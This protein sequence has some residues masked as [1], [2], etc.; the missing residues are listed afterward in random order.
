MLFEG[1]LTLVPRVERRPVMRDA[2]LISRVITEE[3]R[4]AKTFENTLVALE[5]SYRNFV[6]GQSAA[7]KLSSVPPTAPEFLALRAVLL[8]HQKLSDQFESYAE[9]IDFIRRNTIAPLQVRVSARAKALLE[10]EQKIQAP[11]LQ[12]M[13]NLHKGIDNY[14]KKVAK[15]KQAAQNAGKNA[16]A[17]AVFA[18]SLAEMN[19]KLVHIEQHFNA[20]QLAYAE[21]SRAR[22][23]LLGEVDAFVGEV[24][25]VFEESAKNLASIDA[26]I[27]EQTQSVVLAE[28]LEDEVAKLWADPAQEEKP[29]FVVTLDRDIVVDGKQLLAKNKYILVEAEGDQWRISNRDE[30]WVVPAEIVEPF[31][32]K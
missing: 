3:A 22:E 16:Q 26:A 29:P 10:Q 14:P 23:R 13:A 18:K 17:Q 12:A 20:F 30:S 1:N 7:P 5:K 31:E 2:D 4:F 11:C 9:K 32:M 19:E 21:Y 28:S 6:A 15:V 8:S 27:V 25:A 24:R